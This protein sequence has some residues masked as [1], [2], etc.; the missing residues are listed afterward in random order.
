MKLLK[1]LISYSAVIVA[2]LLG[3]SFWAFLGGGLVA[4]ILDVPLTLGLIAKSF[5]VWTG[6]VVAITLWLKIF[7]KD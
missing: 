1:T 6:L 5:L 7:S 3:M 4:A 2:T